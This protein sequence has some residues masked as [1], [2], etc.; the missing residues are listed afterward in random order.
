MLAI[1][2]VLLGVVWFAPNTQQIMARVKP[3]LDWENISRRFT[4]A[5]PWLDWLRWRPTIG[6]ALVVAVVALATILSMSKAR[7]FLYFQF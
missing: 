3:V 4:P 1:G 5:P 6:T 2:I 7:E